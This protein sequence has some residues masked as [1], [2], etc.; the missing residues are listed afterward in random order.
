MRPTGDEAV[1]TV[2]RR[3][4]GG[5]GGGLSE[6]VQPPVGPALR[7][8]VEPAGGGVGG[9]PIFDFPGPLVVA[10]SGIYLAKGGESY[11]TLDGVLVEVGTSDTVAELL[12]NGTAVETLTI[13]AS[14]QT[15]TVGISVSL[16]AGDLLQGRIAT[17]GSGAVELTL[18]PRST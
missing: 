13:P 11:S 10:T 6:Q 4:L 9:E 1:R 5:A 18:L 16:A 8:R 14:S 2:L 12:V 3:M 15:A 7:S 17:P